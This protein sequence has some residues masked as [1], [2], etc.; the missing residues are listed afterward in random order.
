VRVRSRRLHDG[1]GV[2]REPANHAIGRPTGQ[3]KPLHLSYEGRRP[4]T[5]P[6]L[7]GGRGESRGRRNSNSSGNDCNMI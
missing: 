7:R 2:G 5:C 6:V 3:T 1:R 4:K